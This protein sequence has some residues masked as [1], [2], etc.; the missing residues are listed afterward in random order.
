MEQLL[1]EF[2]FATRSLLKHRG[3]T[4]AAILT[5]GL[6]IGGVSTLFTVTDGVLFRSLPFKDPDRLVRVYETNP[7]RGHSR[8]EV[9]WLNFED[10]RQQ[11]EVFEGLGAFTSTS[12]NLVG[13]EVP[14]RVQAAVVSVDTLPILGI[15][16][17]IGRHFVA[18]DD[19]L[20]HRVA[21]LGN[22]LWHSHFGADPE[23]VGRTLQING[24]PTDVV[25]VLPPDVPFPDEKA[26]IWSLIKLR[27]VLREDRGYRTFGVIGRLKPGVSL[28]TARSQMN[29]LADRLEL[30]YP[31][32][33]TGWS[34]EVYPLHTEVVGEVRPAL[35]ILLTSA[36]L[37]LLIACANVANLLLVRASGRTREVALRAAL[38]AGKPQLLY[39]F[40]LESILLTLL[41]G[42]LGLLLATQAIRF[43][44]AVG[45]EHLPRLQNVGVDLRA[46]AFTLLISLA[47]GMV[48]GTMLALKKARFSLAD[49][50]EGG[51]RA[52]GGRRK[53]LAR[54]VLIV[55]EIAVSLTL[56]IGASLML[57]SLLRLQQVD[58]G[59]NP[60]NVLTLELTLLGPRY[61][62][63]EELI[64]YTRQF[65]ERVDALPG[66]ISSGLVTK[67]P[68]GGGDMTMAFFVAGRPSERPED[69]T[70][71]SLR[72]VTPDYFRTLDIPLLRGRSFTADDNAE[73]PPVVLV[74]QS[75]EKLL[76]PN[77]SS[78][79]ARL[80]REGVTYEVIGVVADVRHWGLQAT[81][82]P[83]I[84]MPYEQHALDFYHLVVRSQSNPQQLTAPVRQAIHAI[85]PDQPVFNVRTMNQ[86]YSES[87]SRSNL[88]TRLLLVFAGTAIVLAIVGLYSVIA[89]SFA[90][91][92]KEIGI[93]IAIGA[94]RRDVRQLVLGEGM[95]LTLVGI[96]IG[97][98]MAI[99]TSRLLASLLY[100]V[101]A[102]D[103]ITFAI[104]AFLF[105]AVAMLA[106]YLPAIKA[107]KTD[108]I[109]VLR[110]E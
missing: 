40:L 81:S 79:G 103:P 107:A 9:S 48:L 63:S 34:T 22:D 93:R 52:A 24:R 1:S 92:T 56:L 26:Q 53:R 74:N 109:T 14:E 60:N 2:R 64:S 20:D 100:G 96:S 69:R 19:L 77:G 67:L 3:F 10:W 45:S 42:L 61:P 58:P 57:K 32:D 13:G 30:S 36:G 72:C 11:N 82:K 31:A 54:H 98:V 62:S 108:P 39:H 43:L 15:T 88:Y 65:L 102:Y 27:P 99:S 49:L 8:N 106:A 95:V 83:E 5:L 18:E 91:R 41:G 94:T 46:I 23:I 12:A 90:Q 87:I 7:D 89:Y 37:V 59:F 70:E 101:S 86:V 47:A 4:A 76:W 51:H 97:L 105:S 38:G 28:E 85:A 110:E 68:L 16:P 17:Q 35:L 71:V 50:Q 78:L 84:Y 66:V 21:I 25:G 73:S 33:N 6:G 80:L 75:M 44:R 55:A 104:A 29:A